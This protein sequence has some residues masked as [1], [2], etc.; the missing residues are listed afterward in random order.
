MILKSRVKKAE[1]ALKE[2]SEEVSRQ[3]EAKVLFNESKRQP[4]RAPDFDKRI[5]EAIEQEEKAV[6][7]LETAL[8]DRE[9]V[10]QSIKGI[11]EAY[12]HMTCKQEH[13]EARK[14][15]H[16]LLKAIFQQ[17]SR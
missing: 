15:C 8:T 9:S 10:S 11:G 4:G 14:R 6:K 2:A 7:A 17:L 3:Q 1:K 12:I 13:R 5:T 16:S